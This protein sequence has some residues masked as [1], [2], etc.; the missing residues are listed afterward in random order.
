M[1]MHKAY[2]I[3]MTLELGSIGVKYQVAT[4]ADMSFLTT[5]FIF[6]FSGVIGCETLLWILLPDFWNW[7]II[8]LFLLVITSFCF[9]NCIQN[10]TKLFLTAHSNTPQPPNPEPQ[11]TSQA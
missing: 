11:D 7:Y 6:H 4:M 3:L 1:S 5:M 8:N 2:T 9:F 10:I